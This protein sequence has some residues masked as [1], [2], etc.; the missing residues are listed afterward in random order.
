MRIKEQIFPL[1]IRWIKSASIDTFYAQLRRCQVEDASAEHCQRWMTKVDARRLPSSGKSGGSTRWD[2]DDD[3]ATMTLDEEEG[4]SSTT[5]DECSKTLPCDE[6]QPHTWPDSN[7]IIRIIM[8]FL[9]FVIIIIVT[10]SIAWEK[11]FPLPWG[12]SPDFCFIIHEFRPP[13]EERAKHTKECLECYCCCCYKL[14]QWWCLWSGRRG[15]RSS[16]DCQLVSP[17]ALSYWVFFSL[18]SSLSSS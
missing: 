1:L 15:S 7:L 9:Q 10:K 4:W 14:M 18:L 8:T 6:T 3:N 13:L 2:D 5:Y 11:L 12:F 16:Q 17:A